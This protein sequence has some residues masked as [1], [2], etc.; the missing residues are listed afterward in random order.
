M[1]RIIK[2]I[3]ISALLLMSITLFLN[4]ND[5][6]LL[7]PYRDEPASENIKTFSN[8]IASEK[9]SLFKLSAHFPNVNP[10][11]VQKEIEE[12][13]PFEEDKTPQ[14]TND[15]K[16][17]STI[18]KSDYIYYYFKLLRTGQ[19]L[20]LTINNSENLWSIVSIESDF[21]ILQSEGKEYKVLKK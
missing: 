4:L 7:E 16:F 17:I 3:L 5:R 11:V 12:K 13:E 18:I 10:P 1:S 19:L 2:N 8:E 21:F 14:L 9:Q 20:T 6:S 15:I